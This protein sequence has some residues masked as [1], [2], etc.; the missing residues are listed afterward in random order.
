MAAVVQRWHNTA[1]GMA[2]PLITTS[3][4]S[5]MRYS[6]G[7]ER[8]PAGRPSGSALGLFRLLLVQPFLRY[9][10]M[11]CALRVDQCQRFCLTSSACC[12]GHVLDVQP[13]RRNHKDRKTGDHVGETGSDRRRHGHSP[14]MNAAFKTIPRSLVSR[15]KESQNG[16]LRNEGVPHRPAHVQTSMAPF[17]V[18]TFRRQISESKTRVFINSTHNIP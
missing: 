5:R 14:D 10:G 6:R 15:V 17:K 8:R 3:T 9:T 1:E 11:Q 16:G 18:R 12:C 7:S 4:K 13:G 2:S